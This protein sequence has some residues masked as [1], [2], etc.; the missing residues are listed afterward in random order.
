MLLFSS[1]SKFLGNT[2]VEAPKGTE[3]V[4]DAVRKL[5]VSLLQPG[6]W[7]LDWEAEK[8]EVIDTPIPSS[9][10]TAQMPLA[11]YKCSVSPPLDERKSQ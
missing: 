3:V 1:F 6:R 8:V 7:A 11:V 2:E 5:K 4:K 9:S 10:V